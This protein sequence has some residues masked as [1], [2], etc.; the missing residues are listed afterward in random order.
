MSQSNGVI[1][2]GKKGLKKF[3]FGEEGAPGSEPFVVDVV[4]AFED[5]L[6]IDDNFRPTERDSEGNR[7]IPRVE[8]PA[9]HA[10]A[11]AY[12]EKVRG[13]VEGAEPITTAEALDFMARLREE[14]DA[15]L[16]FFRPKSLPEPGSPDTSKEDSVLQFSEEPAA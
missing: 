9:Y 3:A 8:I 7:N 2:I 15:L 11:V 16:H 12:A 13:N 10:A 6:V 14:Y 5:W 1:R 4:S